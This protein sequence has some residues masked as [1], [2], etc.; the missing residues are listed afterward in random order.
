MSL[1]TSPA[2]EPRLAS[3]LAALEAKIADTTRR[4]RTD[5]TLSSYRSDWADFTDWCATYGFTTLP[6]TPA[7]VAGYIAEM[8]QPDD[9]RQPLKVSTISRRLAAISHYHRDAGHLSPTADPLVRSS[10]QGIRRILGV[11]PTR[12]KGIETDDLIAVAQQA[13]NS[14]R[15][16][17]IR[18]RALLLVGFACGRRRSELAALD[19]A[20]IE[21]H[22]HGVVLRLRRS[23]TD[24]EGKGRRVE[25]VYGERELTCPV[26]ALRTWLAAAAITNGPVWRPINR[27]GHLADTRLS[28]KAIAEIVQ[29]HMAALGHP[30]SDF[31]GHSLRRGMATTA[32]RN[33]AR[34]KTIRQATGHTTDSGLDPYL[35]DAALFDDPASGYLGL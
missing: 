5:K 28:G 32:S 29:R 20:D 3:R 21:A 13:H 15:L 17:D 19:V 30:A 14:T 22:P 2:A 26:R 23:K 16:I 7:V 35:A 25:V 1:E 10:M 9:D 4:T 24:Q 11:A 31:A 6:A 18:D 27:H 12:K 33:G 34:T 8:A